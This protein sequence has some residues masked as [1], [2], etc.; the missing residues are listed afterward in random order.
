MNHWMV[1]AL[2]P[3]WACPECLGGL[4]SIFPYTG[5]AMFTCLLCDRFWLMTPKGPGIE[6][7][8]VPPGTLPPELL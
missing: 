4:H 8:K 5:P 2:D 1:D 7:F 3:K 6:L